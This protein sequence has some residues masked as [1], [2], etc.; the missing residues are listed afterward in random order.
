MLKSFVSIWIHILLT[1][2][3]LIKSDINY[4]TLCRQIY[5]FDYGY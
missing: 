1:T 2:V 3:Y 5:P 4:I